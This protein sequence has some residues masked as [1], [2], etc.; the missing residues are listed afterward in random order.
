MEYNFSKDFFWGAATSATQSEGTIAGD[1]KGENIWDY[2]SKNYNHRF[3]E[4]VTTEHTSRFYQEM[5]ADLDRMAALSFNSFRT[6][7]SWSRLIP[8]G[9]G[10]VNPEAVD[11]YTECLMG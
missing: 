3:F 9:T 7:I 11:F 8:E 4:G 10:E 5:E 1:N 2:A 6:S